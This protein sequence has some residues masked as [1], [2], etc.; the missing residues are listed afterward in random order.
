MGA[1]V[2][3]LAV[4]LAQTWRR[5]DAFGL[6]TACSGRSPTAEF[7]DCAVA[8]ERVTPSAAHAGEGVTTIAHLMST[9]RVS[10]P[11]TAP[12]VMSRPPTTSNTMGANRPGT[13]DVRP[14]M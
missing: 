4:L 5:C 7:V 10:G 9:S 14:E 13:S 2:A 11:S 12:N 8:Q 3:A 1:G 6:I